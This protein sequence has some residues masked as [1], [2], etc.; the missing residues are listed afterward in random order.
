[1]EV[2]EGSLVTCSVG[3][4]QQRRLIRADNGEIRR[5]NI[6]KVV[7]VAVAQAS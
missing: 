4:L 6:D 1:M 7:C 3:L 5:F 2:E